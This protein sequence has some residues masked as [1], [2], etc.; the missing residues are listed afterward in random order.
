MPYAQV[1]CP[2]V[3]Y[4]RETSGAQYAFS[5]HCPS[6]AVKTLPATLRASDIRTHDLSA[7]WSH[8]QRACFLVLVAGDV[9]QCVSVANAGDTTRRVQFLF[10]GSR[11]ARCDSCETVVSEVAES[12]VALRFFGTMAVFDPSARLS[13]IVPLE[14]GIALFPRSIR[15]RDVPALAQWAANCMQRS[16]QASV[17]V[18]ASGE[19]Y[20]EGT[21]EPTR[22][23]RIKNGIV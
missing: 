18:T 14:S 19:G 11:F 5:H 23:T 20:N 8:L 4:S 10:K 6:H 9:A 21:L 15:E 3:V 2:C 17:W 22:N 16:L 13:A 7:N 12:H 1:P